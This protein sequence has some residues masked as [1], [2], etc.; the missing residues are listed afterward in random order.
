MHCNPKQLLPCKGQ[1]P[2]YKNFN[3]CNL[4]TAADPRCQR[5][6]LHALQTHENEPAAKQRYRTPTSSSI[7]GQI[8]MLAEMQQ[9]SH[10]RSFSYIRRQL[11]RNARLYATIRLLPRFVSAAEM[12]PEPPICMF[13]FSRFLP[14]VSD[15]RERHP[16]KQQ[17]PHWHI[18]LFRFPVCGCA[19]FAT[20]LI[21]FFICVRRR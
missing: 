10:D 13:G 12:S 8:P 19:L 18:S 3:A 20:F 7:E 17:H 11:R 14:P 5:P 2:R 4:C 15:Q 16:T 21:Y 9:Y 1:M 6:G